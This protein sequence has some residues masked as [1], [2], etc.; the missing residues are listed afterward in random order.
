MS[1]T[2]C[3]SSCRT[4]H[5]N[6]AAMLPEPLLLQIETRSTCQTSTFKVLIL[7]LACRS[8]HVAHSLR[9]LLIPAPAPKPSAGV[10]LRK[11]LPCGIPYPAAL[12]RSRFVP[13]PSSCNP[14]SESAWVGS[15]LTPTPGIGKRSAAA[16]GA[17]GRWKG[18]L[19]AS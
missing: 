13:I 11:P 5:L 6:P 12:L 10:S 7:H 14:F 16:G 18:L 9:L 1:R 2:T 19:P 15:Q 8:P 17:Q 3:V 4:T